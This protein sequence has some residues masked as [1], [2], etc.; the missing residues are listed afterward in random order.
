MIYYSYFS[1]L[2]PH[3]SPDLLQG[4]FIVLLAVVQLI[5]RLQLPLFSGDQYLF[6]CLIAGQTNCVYYSRHFMVGSLSLTRLNASLHCLMTEKQRPLVEVL[7]LM[8][9]TQCVLA[10]HQLEYKYQPL[11]CN[12]Q[13]CLKEN[14]RILSEG[15]QFQ[16]Q[17][18][19]GVELGFSVYL[20]KYNF[21]NF[22]PPQV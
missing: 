21:F 10:G 9:C 1:L 22:F 18:R 7:F 19:A 6:Y 15:F 11:K 17:S 8:L 13:N 5:T 14:G 3:H 20:I 2:S 16:Q 4:W 12:C